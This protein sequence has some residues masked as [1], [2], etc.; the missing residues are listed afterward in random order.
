MFESLFS[1]WLIPE[2]QIWSCTGYIVACID[3]TLTSNALS[4]LWYSSNDIDVLRYLCPSV[5]SAV[6]QFKAQFMIDFNVKDL[7]CKKKYFFRG[8]PP[9][10]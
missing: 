4:M 6:L 9:D 5:R 10:P 3:G 7:K 1:W 2:L 8:Q